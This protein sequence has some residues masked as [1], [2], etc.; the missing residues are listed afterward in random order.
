MVASFIGI[1]KFEYDAAMRAHWEQHF[2]EQ[3]ANEDEVAS[4]LNAVDEE[5]RG[6]Q[7]EITAQG[8]IASSS[9]GTEFYRVKLETEGASLSFV[10]PNG[11][12]VVLTLLQLDEI[13]A[14]EP[15]KPGLRF[16][17]ISE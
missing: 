15:G 8:E 5:A 17:R 7:I 16:R 11:V 14:Q 13:R 1:W 2:R 3:L 10:K 12:R 9:G 4:A 6:A